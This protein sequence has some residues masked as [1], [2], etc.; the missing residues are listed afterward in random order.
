MA[1]FVLAAACTPASTDEVAA[2]ADG[3]QKLTSAVSSGPASAPA[4]EMDFS[5]KGVAGGVALGRVRQVANQSAPPSQ[6]SAVTGMLIRTGDVSVQVD[7]L[8][9]AMEAVRRL[10]ASLGGY[11]GNVSIATGEHQVRSASLEMKIPAPRFDEALNGMRPLGK[12]QH[13]TTSAQDVGEEFVD[14]TA[15]IANAKRLEARLVSL[16]ATR[17]GKLEDVLAVERELARVRSEIERYEARVRYLATHV[18]TSTIVA[19]VHEK[20]PIV[21]TTPGRN[22]I[23]QAF[24]K[25]WR[26]FVLFVA[27]GIEAMGVVIPVAAVALLGWMTWRRWRRARVVTA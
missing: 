24:V 16:L 26:N 23:T 18:A 20:A 3:S 22:P 25:M 27:L 4:P 7:S 21:A 5:G 10:A 19:T 2:D 9:A 15:R 8:E 1:G 17:T 12:V 11:I 6:P 13:S 14:V